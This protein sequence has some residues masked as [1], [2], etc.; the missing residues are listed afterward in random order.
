LKIIR[1]ANS[2]VQYSGMRVFCSFIVDRAAG[3]I[4]SQGRQPQPPLAKAEKI[5]LFIVAMSTLQLA[6]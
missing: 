2:A 5:R 3:A 4:E 1:W 6:P